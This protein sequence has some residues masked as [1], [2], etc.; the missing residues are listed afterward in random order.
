[1]HCHVALHHHTTLRQHEFSGQVFVPYFGRYLSVT[2][3]RVDSIGVVKLSRVW[4]QVFTRE[5]LWQSRWP[6]M[7]FNR[8]IKLV[9]HFLVNRAAELIISEML[10]G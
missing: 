4:G 7:L 10:Q 2:I 5:I 3:V 9:S 6:K 1:M 8:L